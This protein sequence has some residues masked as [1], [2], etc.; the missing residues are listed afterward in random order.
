M[1]RTFNTLFM[2][3][4]VDGKIST[5]NVDDRDVDKDLPRIKGLERRSES[6][7]CARATNRYFL[8]KHR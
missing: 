8:I 4:S 1:D 3:S 5:G 2:I 7:L 6:V